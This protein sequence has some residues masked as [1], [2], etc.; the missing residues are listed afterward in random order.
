MDNSKLYE[1]LGVDKKADQKAITKA[2]RILAMKH[3][4]DKG[5]DPEKVHY[6]DYLYFFSLDK[7][8][9]QMRF[10]RILKKEN[11]MINMEWKGL[12]AEEGVDKISVIFFQCLECKEVIISQ[13]I[14][15]NI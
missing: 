8:L 7:Y 6:P 11:F 2:F 4:P 15:N 13:K 14:L 3:H 10:Y 12:K 1:I 5:G 9:K